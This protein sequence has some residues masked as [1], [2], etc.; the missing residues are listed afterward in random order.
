MIYGVFSDVHGNYQALKA[1]LEFFADRKVDGYLCCG[2]LVGYG[3]QPEECVGA[4][5]KLP[6][7]RCVIGNHDMAVLGQM[8]LQW[9]N[10]YATAAI[11]YS[12][13]ALSGES[14]R[15]LESLPE[16]VE[17]DNFTLV[18]GSPKS[19]VEEYMLT[20]EQFLESIPFLNTELCFVGHSHMAFY[21]SR[22]GVRF[23]EL[24]PLRGE[25]LLRFEP[26][27]R[28]AVNAGSVGQ[29]RDRDPRAACGIYDSASGTFTLYRLEYQ[30]LLTQ[31]LMRRFNLPELLIERIGIGW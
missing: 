11:E 14:Y 10:A 24:F 23:P 18:H 1:V 29:P 25:A 13:G 27:L 17:Q 2:D 16:R 20:G 8:S 9:F 19:P 5:S 7:L 3:P 28:Y 4:V 6:N 31:E 15:F 26:G 30:R 12:R 21:L 22:T